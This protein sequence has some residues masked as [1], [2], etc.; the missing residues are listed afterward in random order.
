MK[1]IFAV[2]FLVSISAFAAVDS[3]GYT[4]AYTC[5]D[6]PMVIVSKGKD[7]FTKE[8]GFPGA[9]YIQLKRVGP[10]VSMGTNKFTNPVATLT[11]SSGI[12]FSAS[13]KVHAS[14]K[15]FTCVPSLAL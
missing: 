3:A 14:E 11:T 5:Q 8:D 12:T 9:I 10:A 13:L 15:S 4:V 7:L 6:A 2:S 1:T